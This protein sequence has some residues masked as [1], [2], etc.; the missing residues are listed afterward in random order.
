MYIKE[1][2]IRRLSMRLKSPFQTSFGSIQ[3]KPFFLIE[4]WDELGNSGF[5]EST[6]FSAPWYNEETVETNFHIMKDFLIPLLLHKELSHPDEVSILFSSI[7]KNNMAKAAIEGAVWDLYAKR[8]K[9]T[10][11]EALG[12][13]KKQIEVGVSIGLQ[14]SPE[15]LQQVIKNHLQ[16]GYKRI[17][18]KIKPGEDWQLI[19]SIRDTYPDIALM[20]DANS[21]YTFADIDLLKKLDDFNLLMIEQPLGF[22]DIVDHARLQKELKTPI[23]LDESIHSLEDARKAIELG[24]AHIINV[25][26]SRVGGLTEAKKIHD[27]CQQAGVPVWC[28]GMLEAGIGRAHNIALASLPNFSLPGDISGSSR[29]WEKDIITPEVVAENGYITVP[30]GYGIGFEINLTAMKQFTKEEYSWK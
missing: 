15:A 23:C 27:Y 4:V 2:N 17:K 10:L 3:D 14:E 9:I 22:D 18:V 29:Y 6:A 1:I 25:K 21:A 11:S 20:A 28:G 30:S 7:R 8:N 12:G 19:K 16:E 26:T 24:S 13:T 5:G